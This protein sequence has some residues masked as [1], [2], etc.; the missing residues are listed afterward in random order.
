M[1]CENVAG[2]AIATRADCLGEEILSEIAKIAEN[3]FVQIELGLQTSN[4]ETGRKINRCYTNEDYSAAVKRIKMANPNIHIVT[5][6]IFGLPGESELD[7]MESVKFVVRENHSTL[8]KSELRWL[9]LSKPPLSDLTRQSF[10]IKITSLYVVRGTRLAELYASGEYKPLQKEE[11][12]SLLKKALPLLPENCVIHRLS[13]DPPKAALLAPAWTTDK[14][15]V[16]NEIRK[17]LFEDFF[18]VRY[19]SQ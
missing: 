11:Y 1:A 17:L 5:H 9:S 10:G 8:E 16:M 13:G 12:F 4:E 15:R 14:K 19:N 7:M 6:L 18:Y 2:L 3:H